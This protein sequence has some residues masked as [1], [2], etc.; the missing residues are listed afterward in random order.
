ML[1]LT[2][3]QTPGLPHD[4]KLAL[5][6]KLLFNG[7]QSSRFAISEKFVTDLVKLFYFEAHNKKTIAEEN[8]V[9]LE[10]MLSNAY[11]VAK[12]AKEE[13]PRKL[14]NSDRFKTIWGD[15]GLSRELPLDEVF[16]YLKI[17]ASK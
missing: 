1:E 15:L 10:K 14:I 5:T 2:I 11:E 16:D 3:E 4:A 7:Y 8:I 12:S 13:N 17:E 9:P 6:K